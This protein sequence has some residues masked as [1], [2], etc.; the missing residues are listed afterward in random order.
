MDIEAILNHRP[1]LTDGPLITPQPSIEDIV[2]EHYARLA[3]D[4]EGRELANAYLARIAEHAGRSA[5]EAAPATVHEPAAPANDVSGHRAAPDKTA[6]RTLVRALVD[7]SA[8]S[9][10]PATRLQL[11][12][13]KLRWAADDRLVAIY[14]ALALSDAEGG[15]SSHDESQMSMRSILRGLVSDKVLS[16][17]GSRYAIAG[18]T[19][20]TPRAETRREEAPASD[21]AATAQP[22][23]EAAQAPADPFAGLRDVFREVGLDMKVGD[24]D[25]SGGISRISKGGS[26]IPLMTGLAGV[27]IG[28]IATAEARRPKD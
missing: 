10:G 3:G 18:E 17:D 22:A 4:A 7:A 1:K 5:D 27:L 14:P 23:D 28:A 21:D 25:L 26:A 19:P 12:R 6:A 8:R 16:Y 20:E 2:Q 24:V 11:E 15:L 13:E 9:F